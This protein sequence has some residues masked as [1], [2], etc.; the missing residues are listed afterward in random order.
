[1]ARTN[2]PIQVW[3]R[4]DTIPTDAEGGYAG[5]DSTAAA[6]AL[7]QGTVDGIAQQVADINIGVGSIEATEADGLVTIAWTGNATND[8]GGTPGTVSWANIIG[9]PSAFPAEP[10]THQVTDLSTLGTRTD[11]SYLSG[12]GVWTVPGAGTSASGACLR[13]YAGGPEL[14]T[15]SS[16]VNTAITGFGPDGDGVDRYDAQGR[17]VIKHVAPGSAISTMGAMPDETLTARGISAGLSGGVGTTIVQFSQNGTPLDLR[18]AEDYA[19][20]Q[21]NYSNL[22]IFW[23]HYAPSGAT[24][25]V[26][27]GDVPQ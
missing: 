4:A 26:A 5:G 12:T 7:F 22:W 11:R 6:I 9:K 8:G 1:M 2:G 14:H 17:L 18:V 3:H 23:L 19:K 25:R 13:F 16:H 21:G 15:N 10:H 20:I 27:N 24:D